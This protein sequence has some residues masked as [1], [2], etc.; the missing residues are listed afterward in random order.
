M[1]SGSPAGSS[2]PGSEP[3]A[4]DAPLEREVEIAVVHADVV[5]AAGAER[6]PLVTVP[7]PSRSRKAAT[8]PRSRPPRGAA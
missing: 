8:P 1:V 5:A 6:R 4:N 3:P 7:S 2:W